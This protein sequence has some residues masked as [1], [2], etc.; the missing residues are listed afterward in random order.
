MNMHV[1]DLELVKIG[2]RPRALLVGNLVCISLER[3]ESIISATVV[4]EDDLSR[5]QSMN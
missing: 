5:L 3:V 2:L 4:I 1:H